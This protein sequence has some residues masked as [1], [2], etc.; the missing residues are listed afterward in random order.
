MSKTLRAVAMLLVLALATT[1]AA[2]ALGPDTRVSAGLFERALDWALAL[3]SGTDSGLSSI[4]ANGGGSI[5]PNGGPGTDFGG[6][7]DP[8]GEPMTDNGG[9]IDPNGG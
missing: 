5:D 4:W 6:Y 1:G 8:N 2:S 7:I 3:V 9:Y